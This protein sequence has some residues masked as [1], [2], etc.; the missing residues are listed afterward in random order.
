MAS[1][2]DPSTNAETAPSAVATR[3]FEAFARR[4]GETMASCYA[5]DVSFSDP[6]FR[7]LRGEDAR[8]MWRMLTGRSKDLTI[9][10]V[11]QS[12]DSQSATVHWTARYS[13]GATGRPVVNRVVSRLTI[14]NGKI[15]EQRD[16]F[17]MWTWTRQALGPVGLLLGWS[18]FLRKSVQRRAAD[19]LAQFAA[20][21]R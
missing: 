9:E 20:K 4:D 18:P 13:F 15:V 10:F 7:E 14:R 12:S 2:R 19:G 8:N 3:F 16:A 21:K 17:P 1:G 6:V 11:L 5:D